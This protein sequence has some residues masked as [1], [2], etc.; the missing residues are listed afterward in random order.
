MRC[1]SLD[2]GLERWRTLLEGS[3]FD[4]AIS[5]DGRALAAA[6]G[7]RAVLLDARSGERIG[8]LGP[9]WPPTALSFGGDP[10]TLCASPSRAQRLPV[11]YVY[12]M[13]PGDRPAWRP[14][15]GSLACAAGDHVVTLDEDAGL[16]RSPL[17]S[18]AQA[19]RMPGQLGLGTGALAVGPAGE[20][21]RGRYDVRRS[22]RVLEVVRIDVASGAQ[23]VT[24]LAADKKRHP[25]LCAHSAGERVVVGAETKDVLV[26]DLTTGALLHTLSGLKRL[27]ERV[28]ISP[29]GRFVAA[30]ESKNV[31]CWPLG[32]GPAWAQRLD[33]AAACLCFSPDAR[34]LIVGVEQVTTR[35]ATLY[36]WRS[37]DGASAGSAVAPW[38][39]C[40]T[41]LA[42]GP[43]GALY[44]AGGDLNIYRVALPDRW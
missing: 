34:S 38:L 13:T 17:A 9:V 44:A 35:P 43:D 14:I 37:A 4:L 8:P 22:T 27:A 23:H 29:D 1:V 24:E 40:T 28:A 5:P 10:L 21:V 16:T 18:A 19:S 31:M 7:Q 15:A 36:A 6:V 26:Y 11:R 20:V 30:I 33:D 41:A 3:L 32:G 39:G 42:C 25:A 12:L 2:G